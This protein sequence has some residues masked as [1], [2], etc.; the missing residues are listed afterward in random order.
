MEV[1]KN[2]CHVMDKQV[3]K[4]QPPAD[5]EAVHPSES[6]DKVVRVVF[7]RIPPFLRH[8]LGI[9]CILAIP[10]IIAVGANFLA[11]GLEQ[12]GMEGLASGCVAEFLVTGEKPQLPASP[13]PTLP[14]IKVVVVQAQIANAQPA[15]LPNVQQAAIQAEKRQSPSFPPDQSPIPQRSPLASLSAENSQKPPQQDIV[16]VD[17]NLLATADR[18]GQIVGFV[19]AGDTVVVDGEDGPDW[20]HVKTRNGESGYLAG[21]ELYATQ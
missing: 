7:R 14:A 4:L 18:Y 2:P 10:I 17:S 11:D 15:S 20:M 3:S 21:A 16:A 1:R 12:C 13:T 5:P 19:R 6:F 8:P 9:F